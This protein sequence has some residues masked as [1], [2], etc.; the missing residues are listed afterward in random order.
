[1]TGCYPIFL[2]LA[3][4]CCVVIGGGAVA[5]RKVETLLQVGATVTVI[6]PSLT[7]ALGSWAEEGKIR[8]IMRGYR[9][10]D[11]A[12][13]ALAFVATDDPEAN[14][15]VHREGKERG[16]WV[17]AADDP[18][19]CDFILPS[20][21][22][23]GELV[24]AVATG[25]SSPALSRAIRE[26]LETYITEDYAALTEIVAEVRQKL[27]ERSLT[28]SAE[29]WQKALNGDLRR[30]I[31]EGKQGKARNYLLKQLGVET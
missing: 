24:V 28:P 21:L 13:F 30:F 9:A 19:H 17:N 31:R 15:A 6:S 16:V 3:G 20:V 22:R 5:E 11:L 10:G 12:G 1:M 25:G 29:T 8:Y 27:K 23:R 2:N 18:A 4:R 7:K 14:T 26:E